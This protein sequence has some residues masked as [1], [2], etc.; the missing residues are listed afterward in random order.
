MPRKTRRI[1][2]KDFSW[3]KKGLL[4]NFLLHNNAAATITT[5]ATIIKKTNM[6]VVLYVY[7]K[8]NYIQTFVPLDHVIDF[9]HN[10]GR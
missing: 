6:H 8:T 1:P 3:M 5:T 2:K 10:T 4:V 9:A 7:A